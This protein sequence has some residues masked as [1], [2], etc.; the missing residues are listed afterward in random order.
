MNIKIYIINSCYYFSTISK[1]IFILRINLD[2]KLRQELYCLIALRMEF[3]YIE[4]KE[5]YN[6]FSRFR[7]VKYFPKMWRKLDLVNKKICSKNSENYEILETNRA[8]TTQFF[9]LF[10]SKEV[11]LT[12]ENWFRFYIITCKLEKIENK[13]TFN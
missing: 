10:Y 3:N 13:I 4:R 1:R 6:L 9:F 12:R 5:S 8:C 2:N 11:K 7:N